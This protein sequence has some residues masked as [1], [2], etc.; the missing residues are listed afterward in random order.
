MEEVKNIDKDPRD[1][2]DVRPIDVAVKNGHIE[3][4][5]YFLEVEGIDKE[6]KYVTVLKPKDIN[7]RQGSSSLCCEAVY[8]F[9]FAVW[10]GRHIYDLWV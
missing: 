1:F 9:G 6:P 10:V 2:N 7:G 8:K 3:I 4:I 5:K